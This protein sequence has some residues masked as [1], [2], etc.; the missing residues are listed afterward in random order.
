LMM[1]RVGAAC[2]VRAGADAP[3]SNKQ[4]VAVVRVQFNDEWIVR[5]H[6]RQW[7]PLGRAFEC[8]VRELPVVEEHSSVRVC[9]RQSALE[10]IGLVQ[11][12]P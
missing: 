8:R 7:C 12:E 6:V 11:A 10:T 3:E 9:A 2:V 4:D 5:F 1:T